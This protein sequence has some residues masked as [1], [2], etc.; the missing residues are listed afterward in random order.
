FSCQ[1][2][3]RLALAL[4]PDGNT[5]AT[6]DADGTVLLWDLAGAILGKAGGTARPGPEELEALVKQL[7]N[8][9][10]R[11]AY[12]AAGKLLAEPGGAVRALAARLRPDRGDPALRKEI[13]RLI[14][15]LDVDKFGTR[16]KAAARLVELGRAAEPAL[17]KSLEGKPSPEARMRIEQL[18]DKIP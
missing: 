16:K 11:K 12:R 10:A 7:G 4:S 2:A 1:P 5:L 6:G 14:G 17:R 3:G 18:L 8:A 13:A 9:D 15:E